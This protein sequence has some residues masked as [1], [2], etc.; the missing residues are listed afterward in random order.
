MAGQA[1]EGRGS[2]GMQQGRCQREGH[3]SLSLPPSLPPSHSVEKERHCRASDSRA[4][5]RVGAARGQGAG[6]APVA[7]CLDVEALL[8]HVPQVLARLHLL[9]PTSYIPPP[10]TRLESAPSLRQ[11]PAP[12]RSHAPR[13]PP[14]SISLPCTPC[15]PCVCASRAHAED[16]QAHTGTRAGAAATTAAAAAAQPGRLGPGAARVPRR[17]GRGGGRGGVGC[18]VP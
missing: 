11:Q 14:P 16:A 15:A 13:T 12:A 4:R 2:S 18:G 3:R 6:G 7:G 8:H 9:H 1:R 10:P 17:A 5:G